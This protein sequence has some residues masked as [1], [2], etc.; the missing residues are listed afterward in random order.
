MMFGDMGHGSLYLLVG[1]LMTVFGNKMKSGSMAALAQVR[2]LILFM[3]LFA[4]Y[5]GFI[6]N[7]WFAIPINIMGSCYDLNDTSKQSAPDQPGQTENTS[8]HIYT[9]LR[10][11][12]LADG[13]TCV[14][15]FGLDPVWS[16]TNNKLQFSNGIKMKLSVIFGVLHMTF[17][18]IIKGMN[19]IDKKEPTDFFTEVVTGIIILWGLFGWMDMQIIIKWFSTAD[20]DARYMGT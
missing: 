11:D 10:K 19:A 9:R 3:G 15:P 7:E 5:C 2:Y 12:N 6:Y 1:I 17:G 20:I 4:F 13:E 8:P 14:Y 16:I 18:I